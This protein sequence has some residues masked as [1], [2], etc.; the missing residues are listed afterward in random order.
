MMQ[1]QKSSRGYRVSHYKEMSFDVVCFFTKPL[2][3]LELASR[4]TVCEFQG[5]LSLSYLKENKNNL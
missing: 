2:M 5:L 3:Y 1:I 4:V